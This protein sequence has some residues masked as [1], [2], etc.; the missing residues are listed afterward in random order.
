MKGGVVDTKLKIHK[1]EWSKNCPIGGENKE[2]VR[3]KRTLLLKKRLITRHKFPKVNKNLS[4][5]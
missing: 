3:H 4:L 1:D 5:I 2:H